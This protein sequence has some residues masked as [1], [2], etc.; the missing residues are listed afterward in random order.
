ME[1]F[2]KIPPKMRQ[3]ERFVR[4]RLTIKERDMMIK[5]SL[6]IPPPRLTTEFLTVLFQNSSFRVFFKEFIYKGNL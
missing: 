1:V 5:A 2:A 4:N 6:P 3:E